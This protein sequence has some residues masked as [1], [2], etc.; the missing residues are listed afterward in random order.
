MELPSPS[1]T[2]LSLNEKDHSKKDKNSDTAV[3]VTQKEVDSSNA[4]DEFASDQDE[5]FHQLSWQR[6][7]ICLI[8]QAIALGSLS[9]PGTFAVL[10]MVPGVIVTVGMG[11]IAIYTSWI[12]GAVK[13]RYPEIMDYADAGYMMFGKIG[14]IIFAVM[15]V[16]LLTLTTGSHVLTGTIAWNNLTNDAICAVAFSAISAIILFAVALPTTFHDMAFLGYIDFVS[17][18]IAI[19]IT[20]V[21]TGIEASQAVGGLASVDWTAFPSKENP[22][23]FASAFLAITNVAFAY[24]FAQSQ[25]SFMSELRRPKDYTK[26][27][28]ALGIMEIIIY[29]LTG[30]LIYSFCGSAVKSPALLSASPLMQKIAFGVAL[31]V[32]FISGGINTQTAAKYIYGKIYKP[33][34]QHATMSTRKGLISW[35]GLVAVITLIAWFIA[36]LIPFFGALL[37]LISALFISGFTFTF[38]ALM[39]FILLK[40]GPWN[41]DSRQIMLSV[42]NASIAIIGAVIMV[43]GV[44]ASAVD[45]KNGFADGTVGK[46]YSCVAS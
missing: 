43:A 41:K 29:T 1:D 22:P 17:I 38:P 7:T 26:A 28:F 25:F 33:A 12:V 45:I 18:L 13:V 39:W 40:E 44:Y 35:V 30:A 34:S 10:G 24:A 3:D 23:T 32:I 8:V 21:A 36:E 20:I 16:G 4:V 37:G 14:Y 31:P 2:T 5:K 19:F 27:V 15:F 11:I 9:M 6:L 46:P 42:A